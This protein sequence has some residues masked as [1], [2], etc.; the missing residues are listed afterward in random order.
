[1]KRTERKLETAERIVTAFCGNAITAPGS[2]IWSG[3]R[4]VLAVRLEPGDRWLR[5]AM[6]APSPD[7]GAETCHWKF[8]ENNAGENGE[9]RRVLNAKDRP[10][11]RGELSWHTH[12]I[13]RRGLEM[14]AGMARASEARPSGEPEPG[15]GPKA[16]D[17][18]NAGDGAELRERCEEIE[19]E[20]IDRE[21]GFAVRLPGAGGIAEVRSCGS[22]DVRFVVDL[23]MSGGNAPVIRSAVARFLLRVTE[24]LCLA[25][26]VAISGDTA[27]LEVRL[28][29]EVDA[30]SL[31]STLSALA[32]ARDRAVRE[33]EALQSPL[34]AE[35][36]LA[37]TALS[38]TREPVAA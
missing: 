30:E 14:L 21:A 33:I 35:R 16:A 28:P 9:F 34:I 7:P 8:L 5:L 37:V 6:E 38:Q 12:G 23:G 19:A 15:A 3:L 26:A 29:A 24:G 36:F 2:G 32:V 13:E 25:R 22:N 20:T 4:G 18:L 11:L 10:R 27:G 1:M 17:S 31:R